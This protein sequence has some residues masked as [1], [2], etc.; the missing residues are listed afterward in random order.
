[1]NLNDFAKLI[2]WRFKKCEDLLLGAK[3]VEYSR[4]GD[5]LHNF[6]VAA[7]MRNNTPEDALIGMWIKHIISILDIVDDINRG[8]TPVFEMVEEKITDSINY[9]LLLEALFE[10]RKK[11]E[12]EYDP[13]C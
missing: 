5:K 13:I 4:N 6:K 12:E 2:D 3:N 9:L 1:M 10:E 11:G 7:R 8:E